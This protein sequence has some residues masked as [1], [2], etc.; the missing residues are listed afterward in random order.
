MM[1]SVLY[2]LSEGCDPI[3]VCLSYLGAI[4][5]GL[6]GHEIAG[7]EGR[8]SKELRNKRCDD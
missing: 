1:A 8:S 4:K 6:K 3:L 2:V 5:R 7:K